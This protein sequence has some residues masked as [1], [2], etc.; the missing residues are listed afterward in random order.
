MYGNQKYNRFLGKFSDLAELQSQRPT[1]EDGEWAVIL[2]I[3]KEYYWDI[4]AREWTA[5]NGSELATEETLQKLVG[6]E[7]PPYDDI[8]LG[9]TDGNLTSVVYKKDTE[10]VYT[11]NLS[12]TDGNLTRVW[13]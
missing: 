9:Y 5:G 13:Q 12:Y 3:N 11:L 1:G 8:V 2:D 6:F 7:I 10:T 4:S